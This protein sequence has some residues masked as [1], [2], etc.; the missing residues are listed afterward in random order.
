M[1]HVLLGLPLLVLPVF[2]LLPLSAAVPLYTVAAAVSLIVY[3]YALKAM[4]TPRMNGGEAMLGAAGR[5]VNAGK[6]GVTK[7]ARGAGDA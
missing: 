2:W 5:V 1:C 4:N 6:R 7:L 3:V